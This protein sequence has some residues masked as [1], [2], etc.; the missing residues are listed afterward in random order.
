MYRV[1]D[2][3]ESIMSIFLALSNKTKYDF[4]FGFKSRYNLGLCLLMM[5][6]DINKFLGLLI[7]NKPTSAKVIGTIE[8]LFH[9]NITQTKKMP[10]LTL[11][12]ILPLEK[13]L[14]LHLF[15][16]FIRW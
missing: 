13:L 16:H 2:H 3:W 15:L 12:T 8:P 1:S 10:K 14:K 6:K 7:L 9:P 5:F 4:S 11:E